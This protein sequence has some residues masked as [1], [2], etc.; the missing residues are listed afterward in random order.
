MNVKRW[1]RQYSR[2]ERREHKESEARA[3]FNQ[4]LA[5]QEEWVSSNVMPLDFTVDSRADWNYLFGDDTVR[6]NYAL[7]FNRPALNEIMIRVL[8]EFHDPILRRYE[9]LVGEVFQ[10]KKEG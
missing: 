7:C 10:E 5:E 8:S 4:A 3:R 6:W 9:E 2:S 1:R